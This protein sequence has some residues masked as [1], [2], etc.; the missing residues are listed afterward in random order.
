MK[1]KQ[2]LSFFAEKS[3]RNLE[4]V[5][6]FSKYFVKISRFFLLLLLRRFPVFY[7]K[8][9]HSLTAFLSPPNFNA[10]LHSV[11]LVAICLA[12]RVDQFLVISAGLKLG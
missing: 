5:Q 6:H 9:G 1:K 12:I 8:K 3:S 10:S 2:S 11:L 4:P 7:T